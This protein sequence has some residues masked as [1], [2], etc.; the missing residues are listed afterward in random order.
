MALAPNSLNRYP[1]TGLQQLGDQLL[2]GSAD[3]ANI[4]LR[5]RQDEERRAQQL[6]D[7]ADARQFSTEQFDKQ[8]GLLMDDRATE[9]AEKIGDISAARGERI[10]D[11][12]TIAAMNAR[13]AALQR[14]EKLGLIAAPDIGNMAVEEVA[15]TK[16]QQLEFAETE[17]LKKMQE[18]AQKRTD[19]IVVEANKLIRK[20][21][22]D[23]RIA[24][25]PEVDLAEVRNIQ[26]RM[27]KTANPK[28]E[29]LSEADI[30]A[31][32]GEAMKE[33][34]ATEGMAWY[35]RKENARINAQNNKV[36]LNSFLMEKQQLEK[37]HAVVGDT[38][39]TVVADPAFNAGA[40]PPPV[41]PMGFIKV[42]REARED[43]RRA[44]E[45]TGSAVTPPSAGLANPLNDPALAA[46]EAES[47]QRMAAGERQRG[48]RQLAGLLEQRDEARDLRTDL[49]RDLRPPAPPSVGFGGI[50][51]FDAGAATPFQ[52]VIAG[53]LSAAGS[54]Q[55]KRDNAYRQLLKRLASPLPP[56][57]PLPQTFQQT[58][59]P[60]F[61]FR[62]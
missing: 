51:D 47:K 46:Y 17:R 25:S 12:G 5:R 16:L 7:M 37:L 19:V 50:H 14:A 4:A 1:N 44:R 59:V 31:T 8:R 32:F 56:L 36:I 22:E 49:G 41:D 15:L 29:K 58:P 24:N 23:E 55:I 60:A 43:A 62:L 20:I 30:A 3:Y 13:F 38:P 27:A 53:Q 52:D 42:L 6:A 34:E 2:R 9:R 28:K 61:N 21:A 18:R 35:K 48:T 33:Y 57:A 11:A 54:E 39:A 26:E 10:E 40:P 45:G